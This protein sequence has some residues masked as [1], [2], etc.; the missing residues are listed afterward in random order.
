MKLKQGLAAVILFTTIFTFSSL[1]ASRPKSKTSDSSV[2]PAL[3]VFTQEPSD[4][5]FPRTVGTVSDEH[6]GFEILAWED[7][8]IF[9]FMGGFGKIFESGLSGFFSLFSTSNNTGNTKNSTSLHQA[10]RQPSKKL[11]S[12]NEEAKNNHPQ[13][14]GLE[15]I[16]NTAKF[17]DEDEFR[18]NRQN[19]HQAEAGSR[20]AD[21]ISKLEN[22]T[23]TG[24]AEVEELKPLDLSSKVSAGETS[25]DEKDWRLER[26]WWQRG[27]PVL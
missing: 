4:N 14:L 1:Q 24:L 16:K 7:P 15:N 10:T 13:G 23:V 22:R 2:D 3:F 17:E 12:L 8:N 11:P 9:G 18:L 20:L 25:E 21:K 26:K 27:S 5:E 6:D 19:T